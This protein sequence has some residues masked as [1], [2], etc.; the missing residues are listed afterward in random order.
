[1]NE[2]EAQNIDLKTFV[3]WKML[4]FFLHLQAMEN[5][6]WRMANVSVVT[7]YLFHFY[8]TLNFLPKY[9]PNEQSSPL[10]FAYPEH[11]PILAC[12]EKHVPP[13]KYWGKAIP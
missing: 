10:L 6:K 13:Q 8:I 12:C 1:M 9:S 2:I 4:D 7:F 5:V 11:S 3:G